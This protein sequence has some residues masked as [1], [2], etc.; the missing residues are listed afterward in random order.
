M[1]K[2]LKLKLRTATVP[3]ELIMRDSRQRQ[4]KELHINMSEEKHLEA[5]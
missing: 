4:R 1:A 3:E 5:N 2:S